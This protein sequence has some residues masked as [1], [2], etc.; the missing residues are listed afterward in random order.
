MS[1]PLATNMA[2]M[3]ASI[4]HFELVLVTKFSGCFWCCSYKEFATSAGLAFLSF[5]ASLMY[6]SASS[7]L[8]CSG[9]AN[10]MGINA[11]TV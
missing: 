9:L 3:D 5:V 6:F 7:R 11:A 4:T 2:A 1:P 8:T 10:A